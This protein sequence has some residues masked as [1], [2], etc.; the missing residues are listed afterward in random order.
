MLP[1][2]IPLE[3]CSMI[4]L[5]VDDTELMKHFPEV[6]WA[7]APKYLRTICV[8]HFLGGNSEERLQNEL[9]RLY[10]SC[11]NFVETLTIVTDW[12]DFLT[13]F[14]QKFPSEGKLKHIRLLFL[15]RYAS[16]QNFDGLDYEDVLIGILKTSPL[17]TRLSF[18]K[19]QPIPR[20]IDSCGD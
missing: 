3:I 4:Y 10:P 11:G 7:M 12:N 5:A 13:P 2:Q 6:F 9:I 15:R 17:L 18:H 1:P 16:R 20:L 8:G 14:L 19:F